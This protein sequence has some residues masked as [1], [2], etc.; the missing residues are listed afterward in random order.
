[1]VLACRGEAPGV[2]LLYID[3][4]LL[5]ELSSPQAFAGLAAKG[6]EPW[7]PAA[8]L[9][10]AD[11]AVPT[12]HRDRPIADP[13]AR[14]QVARHAANCARYG[15][16]YL[17]LDDVRQGIVHVILP[18][19]VFTLP[20][21]TLVCSDSRPATH[22]AFR[23]LAFGVGASEAECVLATKA[24]RQK[25][26][27]TI[28]VRVHGEFGFGVTAKDIIL[29]SIGLIGTAG[30]SGHLIEYQGD[31]VWALSLEAR[32]TLC[33]MNI[34]AGPGTG[35]VAPD[36][37]TFAW[38]KGRPIAPNGRAWNAAVAY[39]R[40]LRSDVEPRFDRSSSTSRLSHRR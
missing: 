31:A 34:E 29:A 6:L 17:T 19:Q 38:L 22:G 10:V 11:H 30:A 8:N 2:T 5:H 15:I 32:M 23:A 12:G 4:H 24:L 1:M 18:E 14:D 16:P 28:R 3:R 25:K 20:G 7:R 40:T 35:L 37:T 13:M 21:L 26:G 27:L 9:A 36:D 39:W 33:N